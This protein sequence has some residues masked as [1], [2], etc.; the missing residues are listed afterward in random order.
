MAGVLQ[1]Q[2][3]RAG[4]LV[5][6]VPGRGR[7]GQAVLVA[8]GDQGG[9]VHRRQRIREVEVDQAR[10][11][12]G[13]DLD[14]G[15]GQGLVDERDLAGRGVRPEAEQPRAQ[16]AEVATAAAEL[17]GPDR[18]LAHEAEGAG[19]QGPLRPGR[20]PGTDRGGH[21]PD[22]VDVG[23]A[24][25]D[26]PGHPAAQLPGELLGELEAGDPAHRVGDHHHPVLAGPV[27]HRL[28][29]AG[30]GLERVVVLAG[31]PGAAVAA[32]VV[33][34]AAE[35]LGQVAAL[36]VPGVL[37]QRE[38][39]GEHQT[40]ALAQ[41]LDMQPGPVVA[42]QLGRCAPDPPE[43]L[44]RLR[45]LP[46]PLPP[47]QRPFQRHSGP[48][49]EQQP[50]SQQ[51]NPPHGQRRG[52]ALPVPAPALPARPGALGRDRVPPPPSPL[53]GGSP[54][55]LD[56]RRHPTSPC[57]TLP[58]RGAEHPAGSLPAARGLPLGGVVR[59]Y[60]TASWTVPRRLVG[61]PAPWWTRGRRGDRPQVIS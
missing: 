13:P 5:G 15:A 18:V 25:Q 26:Q 29:V 59:H 53:Q 50:P 35:A 49:P 52:L 55:P 56:S 23:G 34:D 58:L 8:G 48:N 21:A 22:G 2:Q 44:P 57:A 11:D 37:G 9:D 14:V 45:V 28:E 6:H 1:D 4:D 3:A 30:Q 31:P 12:L 54:G 16:V 40:R 32:L 47:D 17:V 46:P 24:D 43:R 39:V 38:P 41:L 33:E 51:P 27:E 42:G 19:D 60:P 36:V 10:E 61:R 7:R 20:P